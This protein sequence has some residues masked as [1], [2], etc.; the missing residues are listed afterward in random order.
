MLR[1][2]LAFGLTSCMAEL[3]ALAPTFDASLDAGGLDQALPAPDATLYPDRPTDEPFEAAAD[4]ASDP[5]DRQPPPPPPPPD[6]AAPPPL[7][8]GPCDTSLAECGACTASRCKVW[9]GYAD[10]GSG[11]ET[12]ADAWGPCPAVERHDRGDVRCVSTRGTQR[13]YSIDLLGDVDDNDRLAVAFRCNDEAHT[14]L[15]AWVASHCTVYLGHA[16]H[17]AG[18]AF[19]NTD[20][21]SGCPPSDAW[22]EGSSRCVS[23]GRDGRFRAIDLV[24]DVNDDDDLGVAFRCEDERAPGTADRVER[25]T[26]VFIGHLRRWPL[27]AAPDGVSSWGECPADREDNEGRRRCVSSNGD[28]RFH[29][30]NLHG[31]VDLYDTVAI[32]LR[33]STE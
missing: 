8:P 33:A 20:D 23:S 24:G 32:A 3:P 2:A 1:W 30:L 27:E 14:E 25:A 26:E 4:A 10:N 13:F 16:D 12:P 9:L 19:H 18:E 11:P 7:P 6:A 28:G 22:E 17:N 15:A 21:W 5:V 31:D 29:R